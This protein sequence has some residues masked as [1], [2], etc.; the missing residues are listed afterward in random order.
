M[1]FLSIQSP[2]ARLTTLYGRPSMGSCPVNGVSAHSLYIKERMSASIRFIND[3]KA[4][5]ANSNRNLQSE[6][7]YEKY[8][9]MR[10][11]EDLENIITFLK[12]AS[13]LS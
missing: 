10:N 3:I 12:S 7:S 5:P 4:A 2:I 13:K 1:C 9:T 6:D 11:L 8:L